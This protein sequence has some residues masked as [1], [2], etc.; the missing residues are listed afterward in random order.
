MV[1]CVVSFDGLFF[2]LFSSILLLSLFYFGLFFF[3]LRVVLVV[4]G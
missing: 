2:I 3:S 1:C 4:D